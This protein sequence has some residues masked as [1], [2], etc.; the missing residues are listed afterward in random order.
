MSDR[1]EALLNFLT[2]AGGR[3]GS[4]L[5]FAV[6]VP[7]ALHALGAARYAI[8]A[9]LILAL[10]TVP[11]LDAGIAYSLSFRLS[12]RLHQ[13]GRGAERLQAEHL[14]A[15]ALLALILA[16]CF[17]AGFP[18]ALKAAPQDEAELGQVALGG[19]V[20]VFFVMLS[21][22]YRAILVARS[23]SHLINIIDLVTDLG[24]GAALLAG[25]LA[26]HSLAWVAWLSALAYA[27]RLALMHHLVPSDRARRPHPRWRSL[28]LSLR[29][30][31]AAS[32]SSLLAFVWT[33]ADKSLM[34]HRYSLAELG[35]YSIAYDVTSKGWLLMYAVI[36][37]LF[38]I[39]MRW[40]HHGHADRLERNLRRAL[41]V[42]LALGV[43]TY[44]TLC[45]LEQP[46]LTWWVGG[47]MAVAAKA[48]FYVF[49]LSSA[50]YFGVCTVETYYRAIGRTV[51]IARAYF[52]GAL[53]YVACLA[54]GPQYWG[55]IGIASAHVALWSVVLASLL[56]QF[57]AAARPGSPAADSALSENGNQAVSDA[58]P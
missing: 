35:P 47:P 37:A 16:V 43:S 58:L 10:G 49:S 9:T 6:S 50:C 33:L 22:F 8:L 20:A 56:W 48:Y 36:G 15:Y 1:R 12:R 28:R 30:G 26:F 41:L 24:R 5:I 4:V 31:A 32:A 45:L 17:G 3:A 34:S 27:L 55:T 18:L 57:P 44:G 29:L 11:L 40:H 52:L 42:A 53:A 23:G 38:P 25:A 51:L 14:S 21:A 19:G 7:L 13:V 46:L 39:F 54:I 2:Y